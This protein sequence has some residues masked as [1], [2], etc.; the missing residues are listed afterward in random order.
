VSPPLTGALLGAALAVGLAM[1]GATLTRARRP[2]LVGRLQPYL[3]DILVP[4]RVFLAAPTG[5]VPPL[6]H[7]LLAP[8]LTR[9]GRL[10][11]RV[12]GGDA[13]IRRRLSRSAPG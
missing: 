11:E 5:T 1:V 6:V 4:E 13:S 3:R 12:L 10:L 7:R 9:G 8:Y 2:N